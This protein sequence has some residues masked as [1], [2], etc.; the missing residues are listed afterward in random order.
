MKSYMS[1]FLEVKEGLVNYIH[2]VLNSGYNVSHKN[3]HFKIC[4]TVYNAG[5]LE[6]VQS[7]PERCGSDLCQK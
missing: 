3:F 4:E 5:I 2:E 6:T 7:K 1:E